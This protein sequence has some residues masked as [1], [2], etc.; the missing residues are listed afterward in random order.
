MKRF[1]LVGIAIAAILGVAITMAL[2]NNTALAD[3]SDIEN[4]TAPIVDAAQVNGETPALNGNRRLQ[5]E[6]AVTQND[7]GNNFVDEDGDGIC[8]TCGSVPGMGNGSQH[9]A[10]GSNFVDENGDG[11]CD[12]GGN[13]PGTGTGNQHGSGSGTGT[14][15]APHDGTGNQYGRQGGGKG[16]GGN[17]NHGQGSRGQQNQTINTP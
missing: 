10:A 12:D 17:G 8:D 5:A 14:G 2:V 11:I 13:I 9:G 15:T 7:P 4:G 16:Q 6:T 3:K 1:A